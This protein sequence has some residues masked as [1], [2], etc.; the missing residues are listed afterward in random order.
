LSSKG[1]ISSIDCFFLK[2]KGS[3]V[4]DLKNGILDNPYSM[5]SSLSSFSVLILAGM[6]G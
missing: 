6:P 2:E 5:L 3:G 4:V 1:D